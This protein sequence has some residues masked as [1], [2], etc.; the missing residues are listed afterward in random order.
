MAMQPYYMIHARENL[1]YLISLARHLLDAFHRCPA[2][3][4]LELVF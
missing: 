4:H 2:V 3:H 1:S